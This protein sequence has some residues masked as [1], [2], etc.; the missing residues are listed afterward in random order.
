[1]RRAAQALALLLSF[2]VSSTSAL[3]QTVIDPAFVEFEPSPDH[4]AISPA[5]QPLVQ[6]YDFLLYAAGASTPLRVVSLGKPSPGATGTIRLALATILNPLPAAG[7]PYE[8]RIAAVG[9]GGSTS[10]APSNGFSFALT[11]TYGVSPSS[12]S[13]AASGSAS[14]FS[15]TAPAGC[16]WTAAETVSW[17][18]IT[19][20]ATG[21]GNGT[22]AFTVAANA[23]TA[24]RSATLTIAGLARGVAQAGA[25]CTY[26]VSPVAQ[27]VSRT[28]GPVTFSVTAPAGCTWSSSETAAWLNITTGAGGSGNGAVTFS[29]AAN[30]GTVPRSATATIAGRAVT[31]TQPAG[32]PSAPTGFRIV[33]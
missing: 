33:K 13:I 11:C 7:T 32:T 24:S 28:G 4:N 27:S 8:V 10:S 21:S 26:A 3:A 25:A 1:M 19:S 9:A 6:R 18:A 5:G 14:T 15:V 31:L 29:V 16:G 22:V 2:I 12:R 23:T 17:I 30:T 20:G